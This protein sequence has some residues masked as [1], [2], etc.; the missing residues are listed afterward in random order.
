MRNI[1][2]T[3]WK[4]AHLGGGYELLYTPHVACT[5]ARA[6]PH[7]H[8]ARHARAPRY[9]LLYTPHMA[10]IDLWKTSGHFDFYKV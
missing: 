7:A 3:Y 5:H 8:G 1:M 10:S 9:E 4:E 6:P 2:E